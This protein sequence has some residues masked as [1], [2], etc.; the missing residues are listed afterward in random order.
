M[1]IISKET[2]RTINGGATNLISM[3]K[4]A[5]DLYAIY[6]GSKLCINLGIW[7]GNKIFNNNAK[8]L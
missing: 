2:T 5:C 7:I 3:G 8:Y 6:K 4:G 1:K